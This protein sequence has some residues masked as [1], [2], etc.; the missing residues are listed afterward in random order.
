V[1]DEP[2][3]PL[4]SKAEAERAEAHRAYNEA[5]DLVDRA[6]QKSPDWPEA[7]PGYDEEKL[8]N[9]N[10]RWDILPDGAVKRPDGLKGPMFDAVWPVLE[11]ILRQQREFNSDLVNHLNRNVE[12]HRQANH[13]L[14]LIVP[15]LREGFNGL[16]L[17][18]HLTVHFLQ[19]IT[20]F[21]DTRQREVREAVD[22]LRN[23][24][25]VAQR[26]GAMARREIEKLNAAGAVAPTA[27]PNLPEPSGT[28][29]NRPDS[30]T[31]AFKYVGFEDRFRGSEDE[32]R[33]RL[34][35]YVPYFAGASDVLDVGCGRGEFLDLLKKAGIS[36]RGLD[37]NP[38]MVEV[39]KARG[40]DATAGDAVSYLQGLPDESLGGLL[41]IQVVEHLEPGY[42]Q[43][44]LQ[45]A[46]YKLRPGAVMV[47]ETINPACWVAFFESYIRDLTHV[48]PIHPE[49]LQYLLHASGF[50]SANI[51]YR[52]PIAEE[53]RLQKVTPSVERFGEGNKGDR[54][55]D[56]VTAF[57][58]NMDRLNSHMFTFQDYAAVAKRP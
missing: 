16:C 23:V 4:K 3:A 47:L 54:L 21:V 43:K 52:A 31:D 58:R 6:R 8:H 20:P 30:S 9:L 55:D 42:L 41:A 50:S 25:E 5:F 18:E 14:S 17:F 33:S 15:G 10:T 45:T 38:E 44:F 19:T 7:P 57:N 40:L 28:S 26:A 11:P 37:L 48:R 46:F 49:T 29:P 22:E 24:A 39:C 51:V 56:L 2:E 27:A 36:G 12:A 53:A 35:D 34:T 32:I 1:A 13:A